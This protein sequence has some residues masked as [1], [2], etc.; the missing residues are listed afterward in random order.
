VRDHRPGKPTPFLNSPFN[1]N[2]A[3]FSPDGKWLA[4]QSNESERAEVSVRPF[5]GPGGKWQVSTAGG[6]HP[7]WSRRRNELFY[8]ARPPD[9]SLMVAPF[10]SEAGSF[11]AQKPRQWSP[12]QVPSQGVG[13]RSFDLHPDGL[14]F[15]VLMPAE[16]LVEERRDHVVFVLNFFDELRRLAPA[17]RR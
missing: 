9:L 16:Q 10:A 4:Y 11:R 8:R 3:A 1:E 5:P 7:T 15:A 17:A 13:D 14:R 12:R 2:F 6:S